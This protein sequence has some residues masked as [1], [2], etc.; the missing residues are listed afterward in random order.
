MKS[1]FFI[2]AFCTSFNVYSQNKIKWIFQYQ[3]KKENKSQMHYFKIGK[4]YFSFD[5]PT[6]YFYKND[7]LLLKCPEDSFVTYE[8]Y[9]DKFLIASYYT[10]SDAKSALGP[11][12]RWKGRIIIMSLKNPEKK[13]E[14]NLNHKFNSRDIIEFEPKTG[15][16]FAKEKFVGKLKDP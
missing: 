16:L 7:S 13:W 9:D 15:E 8:V 5:H 11:T 2:L 3:I 14:F 10:L 12:A 4:E 1:I 6:E